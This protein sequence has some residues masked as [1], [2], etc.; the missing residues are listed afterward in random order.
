MRKNVRVSPGYSFF[1]RTIASSS[2]VGADKLTG[3]IIRPS[4]YSQRRVRPTLLVIFL[5]RLITFNRW[6]SAG[7][8]LHHYS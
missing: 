3:L 6:P 8:S 1:T 7:R 4:D 5:P 2:G